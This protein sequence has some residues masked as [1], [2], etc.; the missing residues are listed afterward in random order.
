MVFPYLIKV[1]RWKSSR[2][3][4]NSKLLNYNKKTLFSFKYTETEILKSSFVIFFH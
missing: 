1:T 4:I 2:E 3:Y